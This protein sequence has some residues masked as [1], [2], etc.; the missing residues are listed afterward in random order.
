MAME[1]SDEV[2]CAWSGRRRLSGGRLAS[3]CAIS[4]SVYVT[5]TVNASATFAYTWDMIVLAINDIDSFY[6]CMHA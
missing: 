4:V 6:A 3:L 2:R 5:H 1:E